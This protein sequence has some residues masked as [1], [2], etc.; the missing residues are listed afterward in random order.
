VAKRQPLKKPT[1]LN[2]VGFLFLYSSRA[3]DTAE[4]RR[5]TFE[6]NEKEARTIS[7][8]GPRRRWWEHKLQ[9]WQKLPTT[10]RKGKAVGPVTWEQRA[11]M[12]AHEPNRRGTGQQGPNRL[13][14]YRNESVGRERKEVVVVV[15]LSLW[16]ELLTQKTKP[17]QQKK[18]RCNMQ[19]KGSK[20][21]LSL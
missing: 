16:G 2:Y 10:R 11:T 9:R 13:V 20:D 5:R 1:Y 4:D 17:K 12:V 6:G 19:R 8:I 7:N 18:E 21:P 14:G 15:E 3:Q